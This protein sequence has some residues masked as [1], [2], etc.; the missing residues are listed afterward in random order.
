MKIHLAPVRMTKIK[1]S[2]ASTTGKD[3]EQGNTP[4]LLVG[5]QTRTSTL[6]INL[7]VSQKIGNYLHEDQLY[8]FWAYIQTK[9]QYTTGIL[10]QLCS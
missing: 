8:Y 6:E 9:P 1:N 2:R 4:P 10:A 5:V 7:A 3:V